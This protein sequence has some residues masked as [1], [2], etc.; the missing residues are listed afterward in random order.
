MLKTYVL[1]IPIVLCVSCASIDKPFYWEIQKNGKTSH[2][3]GTIHA[4]VTFDELPKYISQDHAEAGI[5]GVEVTDEMLLSKEENKENT[6]KERNK[7]FNDNLKHKRSS[8]RY[9]TDQ[10]W[11]FI[12]QSAQ[13][14]KIPAKELEYYPPASIGGLIASNNFDK[15]NYGADPYIWNREGMDKTILLRAKDNS[16]EVI[17]FDRE[18]ALTVHCADLMAVEGVKRAIVAKD[19]LQRGY[20]QNLEQTRV[21]YLSGESV[22]FAELAKLPP[23]LEKCL[24]EERNKLWIP[25]IENAHSKEAKFFGAVGLL[26][27]IGPENVLKLLEQRGFTVQRLPKAK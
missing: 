14:L 23:G 19:Q 25:I 10:E 3:L 2:L 24:L 22:A 5:V 16:K 6:K 11:D 17:R 20:Q 9:F 21:A 1:L 13:R 7:Q 18:P 4:G 27:L 8:K 12:E 26:H 15:F